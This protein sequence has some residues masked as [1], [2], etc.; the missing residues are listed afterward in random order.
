[1]DTKGIIST[2]K[3]NVDT[4]GTI[5]TVLGVIA[6]VAFF[7]SAYYLAK[8]IGDGQ[9]QWDRLVYIFGGIEAVAFA[10]AGY[11][12]GKEVNRARAETAEKKAEDAE[13]TAKQDH[14]KKTEAETHLSDLIKYIENEAPSTSTRSEVIEEISNLARQG[15]VAAKA[16]DFMAYIEAKQSTIKAKPDER[17]EKLT[18]YAKKLSQT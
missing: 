3:K 15:G 2:V 9:Q 17:W 14:A 7:F 13:K 11:F 5:A 8:H 6:L 18:S 4:K 16:P 12:F 1:M 10:A